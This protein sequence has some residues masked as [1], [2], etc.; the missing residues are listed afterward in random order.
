MCSC[1]VC[2]TQRDVVK[3]VFFICSYSVGACS[4]E[5]QNGTGRVTGN[6]NWENVGGR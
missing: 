1:S 3:D 2:S 6:G 5:E 4:E